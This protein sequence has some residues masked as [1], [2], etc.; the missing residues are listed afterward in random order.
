MSAPS[1]LENFPISWFAVVMGLAGLDLAWARAETVL[2]LPVAL[3]PVLVVLTPAVFVV[4]ATLY[5]AK[6]IRHP[7][8]VAKELKHPVKLNFFATISISLIL[9]ATTLVHAAPSVS[10]VLWAAG[11]ALHL[12]FTLYVL[13]VWIHHTHFEIAHINPAWFIPIVGN[14]LVPIAG[15]H[16]ASPEISWFFFSIGLVFWLLLFTIILYRV[17]FHQPLPERMIPTLFILIAPPAVGFLSWLQLTD[18]L[19]A[20]ARILYY[21][22]LFL[23]LLLLTQVRRFARLE[24]FLSWWAYSFPMAAITVATV[25]MAQRTGLAFFSGLAMVLL[26]LVSLL[27]LLLVARTAQGVAR[28]GICVDE[29]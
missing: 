17:I 1:R 8:A 5:A 22:A 10:L 3:S 9:I 12:V 29:G 23:T 16:H 11:A 6:A 2:T 21:I 15:V 26:A 4:L 27:I 19:D 24:F 20:F 13:S 25:A 7:Q 14:I 28:R 18:S